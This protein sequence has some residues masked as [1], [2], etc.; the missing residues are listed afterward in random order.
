MSGGRNLDCAT[1]CALLKALEGDLR[2]RGV[3]HLALVGSVA[4][5]EATADSDI[6]V[7]IHTARP[8]SLSRMTRLA[9]FLKEKT[10]RRVD[11]VHSESVYPKY[12]LDALPEPVRQ[13]FLR[14]MVKVF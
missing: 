9:T 2:E 3:T 11:V 7:V 10:G 13:G 4:R 6:D 5:G 12:P 8:F 14:D 1:A